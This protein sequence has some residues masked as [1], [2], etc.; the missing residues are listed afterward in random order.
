VDAPAIV[1]SYPRHNW[2]PAVVPASAT[3]FR[4][5]DANLAATLA[6]A[7]AT[8][9][10]DAPDVEITS[11]DAVR[12]DA[13]CVLVNIERLLPEGGARTVRAW[14]RL[15]SSVAVRAAAVHSRAVLRRSGYEHVTT[16]PW[17]WEQVIRLPGGGPAHDLRSAERLP[18]GTIVVGKRARHS[19]TALDAALAAAGN[20]IGTSLE[21]SWPLVRQGG[22]VALTDRGV[23]RVAIGPAG[24]ELELVRQALE[25]LKASSP[26]A[27]VS[28]RV[29]W[30]VARGRT[31]LAEW[32]IER[33]LPGAP[34]SLRVGNRLLAECVD[35]L[36][37]LHSVGSGDAPKTSLAERADVIARVCDPSCGAVLRAV[38]GSLDTEL[39]SVPRGFA[40]G[41]FWIENLLTED[42]RLVGVVDWHG[43]G[44]GRLPLGDLLHLRLSLIFGR[45]R[46]FLGA[47]L[48]EHLLPELRAGGDEFV[49]LY[50]RRIGIDPLP[51]TLEALA[52][53]YWLTRTA[54]EL[55]T[56]A[57]RPQR[58]LWIRDNVTLVAT[59]LA[60]RGLAGARAGP[61]PP[62]GRAVV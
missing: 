32:S 18:L 62:R 42:A 9:A 12:G 53:A 21:A 5:G 33:R 27:V 6:Y 38:A 45:T 58:P 54:R 22:L 34:P 61:R 28:E 43:A 60:D 51:D 35:F 48:V 1:A 3:R 44:P 16:V 56:Y 23:V 20:S 24:A 2:L 14:N 26:P 10:D 52:L 15:V 40:H 7:G 17:E 37:A 39:A 13:A 47:A 59:H 57:D 36:V 46:Q 4:V 50:C 30:P 41:D 29:P 11:S 8:I 55:E 25:Q 49:R 19:P 31:G